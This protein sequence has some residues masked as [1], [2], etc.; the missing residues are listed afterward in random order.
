MLEG[1]SRVPLIV[2]W[3]GTTPAGKVSDD[4]I[5]ITD[6]FSTCAELGGAKLPDGVTLDSRSFAPQIKGEKGTPREWVYV[7]L[8]GKSYVRNAGFKLTNGGELFDMSQAPF[9]EIGISK[10]TSDDSAVAARAELQKVLD[11][12]PTRTAIDDD[13]P[14]R[15]PKAKARNSP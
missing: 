13:K 14:V 6:F 12:H 1:G 3:P 5:D 7:E 8:S 11:R 15:K 10:D 2:N 4:L 9:K